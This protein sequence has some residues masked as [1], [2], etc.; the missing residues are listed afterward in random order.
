MMKPIDSQYIFNDDGQSVEQNGTSLPVMVSIIICTL[1]VACA[2]FYCLYPRFKKKSL[3]D[4][5]EEAAS[6][7][8]DELTNINHRPPVQ[9]GRTRKMSQWAKLTSFFHSSSATD[10]LNNRLQSHESV[11]RM[12]KT[13]STSICDKSAM[14]DVKASY[15]QPQVKDEVD[16]S[17]QKLRKKSSFMPDGFK[18]PF[19]PW[20]FSE[21][22]SNA[23]QG[24]DYLGRLEFSVSYSFETTTLT[25]KIIKATDLPAMD[26]SGFSDPFVKCCLLPDR[27][28]KLETK[29][30]RK[31]LNPTWNETFYFEGLPFDKVQQRVLYMQVLDWDRFSRNDPIGEVCLPLHQLDL[32]E[33]QPQWEYLSRCK[34]SNKRGELLVSLCYHPVEGKIDIEIKQARNLKPMDIGGTSDPYVKIWQLVRG[35]RIDKKKTIT[36]KNC[37]N[38]NF[39]ET[40]AFAS[41]MNSMR[42]TQLEISVMD[43]DVIGRNEVIGKIYLGTKSNSLE[44]RHWKEMLTK[45]RQPVEQWHILKV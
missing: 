28:K 45:V 26:M 11:R 7:A 18:F 43:R 39:N 29:I 32:S 21:E 1:T 14:G 4:D 10:E 35:K 37:L 24:S 34:G 44:K 16:R 8:S 31:N 20:L 15:V 33:P 19:D 30:R 38:P 3:A 40:F 41:P 13:E 17:E 36:V 25:V 9:G 5:D 6:C 2:C 42:E 12:R 22:P 27:K 23:P